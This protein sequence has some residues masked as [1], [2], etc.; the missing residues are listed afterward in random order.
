[1]DFEDAAQR[2]ARDQ[3]KLRGRKTVA[4]SAKAKREADYRKR[5]QEQKRHER[6]RQQKQRD[7]IQQFMT[8]CDRSLGVKPLSSP[9]TAT[10]T[11]G[12]ALAAT[13]IYGEGDKIAL[14]PSVLERLTQSM[15]A[16]DLSSSG[17]S[18][19]WLFR[20]GILNPAYTFPASVL[21][22]TL[23]PDDDD[24]DTMHDSE[25]E[26]DEAS[27]HSKAAYLDE[28]G[29]KYISYTHGTVVEF[30][31]DEGD[32]GLPAPIAQ[33]LLDPQ[34]RLAEHAEF[35]IPVKR[36]QDPS[37]MDTTS[38]AET[39]K[40]DTDEHTSNGEKRRGY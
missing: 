14:P 28:L 1:M 11:G 37:G 29:H 39:A 27:K 13:S 24:D 6:L 33:A 8:A 34:R 4:V 23:K 16:D 38:D 7:F 36:T 12:L 21:L 3:Q 15:A 31:Q 9:T 40:L 26:D 5:Q 20:I 18:S 32:V 35:T 30:T 17:S 22:Q 19:P 25:D 2:L 10:T